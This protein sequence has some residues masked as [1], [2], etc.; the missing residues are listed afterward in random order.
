MFPGKIKGIIDFSGLP[1]AVEQNSKL[2]GNGN[3]GSLFGVLASTFG[4]FQA[5][6]AQIAVGTE[7]TQDILGGRDEQ[8]TQI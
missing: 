1:K 7:G 8:T 5:P 4:E 6:A 2:S 3:H